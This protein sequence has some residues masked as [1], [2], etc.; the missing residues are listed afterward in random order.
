MT[1][2]DFAFQPDLGDLSTEA[3]VAAI[4]DLAEQHGYFEPV[5]PHHHATLIDAGPKLVVTFQ[6]V[7]E[8][9]ADTGGHVPFGWRFAAEDGWSALSLLSEGQTWFRDRAVYGYFD[10][11][12]DDGFFDEFETVLFVGVGA[13]GYAA[14]AYSVAAPGARVLAIRPQA[15]LAP[16]I[17]GWDGRFKAERRRD[18]T[19]RYGYAPDMT[20][21]A[22]RVWIVHDPR[23]AVDAIHA[24]LFTAPHTTLLRARHLGG[25]PEEDLRAMDVLD[26]LVREAMAGTLD[27]LT[28]SRL[29][30][31]RREVPAYMRRL[32]R[33]A[34]ATG[35][36]KLEAI[37]CR[38]ALEKGM[39]LPLFRR[40][41]RALEAEA[42]AGPAG[43]N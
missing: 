22:E 7:E 25:A 14:A 1:K 12:V 6:T 38:L 4:D 11:L 5:G 23:V 3:W 37:V 8:A 26:D 15:T 16:A 39:T 42:E 32:T 17:A 9:R 2:M 10:R 24:A 27:T 13:A 35:H 29:I 18:F 21:G 40:R 36:P 33:A 19:S 31:G 30:R 43:A 28:F 34:Q 20:D 41:L